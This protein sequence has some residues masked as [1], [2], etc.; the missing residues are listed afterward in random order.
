[1][2]GLPFFDERAVERVLCVAA[3]PDDLE[4]GASAAV[5][6]W[7]AR[8]IDVSYLL[9]TAG[10]AGMR[11]RPPHEVAPLR[12][13]EQ[14]AACREVG[15]DD[16]VILNF[17]D[18]T[19]E[20]GLPVREAIA[21]AIRR[22]R[23][24]VVLTQPW[25]LDVSWGLNHADHRA[26]GI[27]TVDAIRDADNPWVFPG[28]REQGLEA[29]G[30]R[31]LLVAGAEPDHLIDVS[32]EPLEQAVRSLQAHREYL[33]EIGGDFDPRTMLEEV[34]AAAAAQ[35]APAARGSVTHALGVKA[36]RMG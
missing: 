29:W 14:R 1:M 25:D 3:H 28:L 31:W 5:A 21:G 13:G 18:G 20:A 24:Q 22:T 17:P 11:S 10:E 35:A 9:L 33:A 27:A 12:A 32:G 7:R 23:P 2:T 26:A 15:V 36:Y 34:T 30:T 16:L 19:L 8:G 4:Y 6:R